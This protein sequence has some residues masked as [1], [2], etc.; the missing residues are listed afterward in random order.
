MRQEA[1][2]WNP[3]IRLNNKLQEMVA[4]GR[5]QCIEGLLH[6]KSQITLGKG[7]DPF[8]HSLDEC[9]SQGSLSA[10]EVAY[11][12]AH[13]LVQM[14]MSMAGSFRGLEPVIGLYGQILLGSTTIRTRVHHLLSLL[15]PRC[16]IVDVPLAPA[17]GAYLSSV[18]T[19]RSGFEEEVITNLFRC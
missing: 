11:D 2:M 15:F 19:R 17:K 12:L 3:I 16:S 7:L 1:L 8:T 13:D 4:A 5:K 18:L 9:V 10:I 6:L 14:V